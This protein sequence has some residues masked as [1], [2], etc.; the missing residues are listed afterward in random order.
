[1]KFNLKKPLS[2][3]SSLVGARKGGMAELSVSAGFG[4]AFLSLFKAIMK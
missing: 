4:N 1:M 3:S 2:A